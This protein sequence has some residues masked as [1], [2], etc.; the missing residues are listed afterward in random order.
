MKSQE[1]DESAIIEKEISRRKFESFNCFQISKLGYIDV[2]LCTEWI[3]PDVC[4]CFE[5]SLSF[6]LHCN[7][8][9][10][11]FW[12]KEAMMRNIKSIYLVNTNDRTDYHPLFV[13][14]FD[15]EKSESFV[16]RKRDFYSSDFL[17]EMERIV[18]FKIRG[19]DY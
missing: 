10:T 8:N 11:S 16:E 18:G 17:I 2:I 4:T 7:D 14:L 9:L 6:I 1:C 3:F 12:K 5:P 15:Q 13:N 19:S